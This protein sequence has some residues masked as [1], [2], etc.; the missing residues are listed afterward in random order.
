MDRRLFVDQLCNRHQRVVLDWGFPPVCISW[1]E[2]LRQLDVKLFWFDGDLAQA[3]K[4]FIQ[5]DGTSRIADFEQQ[6]LDIKT[7]EYPSS[8]NCPVV[9]VLDS[10]GV[11]SDP[12]DIERSIFGDINE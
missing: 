8:L 9:R 6:I 4:S 7:A 5:R 3:R 12:I 11:F 1:V 10:D 2:E